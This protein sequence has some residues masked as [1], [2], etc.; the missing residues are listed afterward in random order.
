MCGGTHVNP[1]G[2]FE[3]DMNSVD[4]DLSIRAAVPV[5]RTPQGGGSRHHGSGTDRSRGACSAGQRD[6]PHLIGGDHELDPVPGAQFGE[7][8]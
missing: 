8:A 7:Q 3:L 6:E 1:Y 4:L 2:R 5:P